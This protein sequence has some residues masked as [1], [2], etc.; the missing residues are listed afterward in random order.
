VHVAVGNPD[1]QRW[2]PATSRVEGVCVGA[3]AVSGGLQLDGGVQLVCDGPDAVDQPR[4]ICAS[5]SDDGSVTDLDSCLAVGRCAGP[6]SGMRDI[7]GDNR[8]RCQIESDHSGPAES[9]FLLY[10][11]DR[12]DGRV[13]L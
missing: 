13:R 7:D 10:S 4:V 2:D 12:T 3:G 1:I 9:Q 8:V 6:I 5:S 11:R